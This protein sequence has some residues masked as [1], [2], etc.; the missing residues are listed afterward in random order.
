M[1]TQ[2]PYAFLVQNSFLFHL[3][4]NMFPNFDVIANLRHRNG[5]Y[6]LLRLKNTKKRDRMATYTVWKLQNFSV[7]Q[8][9]REI[10]IFE[11]SFESCHSN[12]LRG[13]ELI[14]MNFCIF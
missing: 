14:L 6:L 8:I 13:T 2:N 11:A 9:L 12:K 1:N 5:F 7:T 10:K 4:V 3:N